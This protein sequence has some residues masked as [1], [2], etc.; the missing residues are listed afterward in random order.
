MTMSHNALTIS[1]VSR[2]RAAA[3]VVFA[4]VADPAPA[5]DQ[6]QREMADIGSL[7]VIGVALQD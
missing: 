1:D 7:S 5:S 2:A 3:T 4:E 6:A